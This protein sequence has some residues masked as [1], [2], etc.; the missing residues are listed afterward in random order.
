MSA[1]IIKFGLFGGTALATFAQSGMALAQSAETQTPD[2]QLAQLQTPAQ[3][4]AATTSEAAVDDDGGLEEILVT[5]QRRDQVQQDVP[6]SIST[7]TATEAARSGVWG[8]ESLTAAVPSLQFSRQTGN[9][10][11][12][13]IRGVGST[14]AAAGAESSV[15]VYVDDVYIG[16]PSANI[17]AF[18]NIDRIEVLKGPQGTLF[19]RNATGGVVHIRTR[20]PSHNAAIDASI[21]YGNYDTI[22]G[23]FFGTTGVSDTLAVSF[24][25]TG[26]DQ[27]DG[28]G[29]NIYTGDDVFKTQYYG[30]RAQALWEPST[31]TTLL[32]SG[33]Y[34]YNDSDAGMNVTILPGHVATGGERFPGRYRTT[35]VPSDSNVNEQVGFSARLDHDFGGIRLANIAAYRSSSLRYKIDNDSSP[36]VLF[37]QDL[38]VE[39]ETYS[40]ELQLLSPDN[41][42][43]SW[44]AGVFLYRADSGYLP[45]I[46]TGTLANGGQG[47]YAEITQV[48]ESYSGFAEVGYELLPDTRLTAG[49]RYTDDRFK[50]DVKRRETLSGT[51]LAPGPF[52]QKAS[53]DKWTYR[54]VLDHHITRDVMIYG[55]ISRGF[56]SGG[57]NLAVPTATIGG[58]AA[59]APPV[60]PEVLDAL[61]IGFKS[62]FFGN[63]LRINAAA[64]HYD[65]KNLQVTVLSGSS[66]ILI[67]AAAAKIKGFDLDVTARPTDRLRLWG[68]LTVLDSKFTEFPGGPLLLPRPAVCAPTPTVTGPPTGGNLTCYVDLAGNDTTRAPEFT[69]TLNASYTLPTDSGDFA[70]TGSLYHN[71]GFYWE[72]DNRQHQDSF[73]LVN[74]T[75]SW[76]SPDGRYEASIWGRNLTDTYR[77]SYVSTTGNRTSGSPEAPRTFGVTVGVHFA[78]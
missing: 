20:R 50:L 26:S 46:Q 58:V 14:Q 6:I 33:D 40:E 8:S 52:E 54:G 56:K 76:T 19:G 45:Q 27:G 72:P 22:T 39:T 71:S 67:N 61:E 37:A 64:Y 15:A 36:P 34:F 43:L 35:A 18:N 42:P 66:G 51:V 49:I 57:Y 9:G 30:F 41:G 28:F 13:F 17:M 48:L 73:Q 2:V 3:A 55:S 53:F 4:D 59:P 16:A 25:A 69:A 1:R 63:R 70:L 7:V 32:I 23:S 5:A 44:I 62:E 29:R 47:G 77:Y 65:Y 31:D 68:G 75:L 78:P 74:A 11:T 10:G 21:G 24:A 38:S 12:P 60:E